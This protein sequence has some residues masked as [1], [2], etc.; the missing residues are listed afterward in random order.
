MENLGDQSTHFDIRKILLP[1]NTTVDLSRVLPT[2]KLTTWPNSEKLMHSNI[3]VCGKKFISSQA[4]VF[5]VQLNE[6]VAR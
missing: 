1:P 5:I 6:N 4:G 3:S 2:V